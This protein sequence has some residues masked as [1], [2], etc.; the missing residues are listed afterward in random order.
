MLEIL[1][2][3]TLCLFYAALASI[4]L[5]ILWSIISVILDNITDKLVVKKL[6]QIEKDFN[7][8]KIEENKQEKQKDE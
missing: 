3:L 4:S 7:T 5:V 2:S 8:R 6:E 1:R